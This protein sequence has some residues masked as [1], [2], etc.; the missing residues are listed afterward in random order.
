MPQPAAAPN[1]VSPSQIDKLRERLGAG[2]VRTG[3]VLAPYTTFQIGGPADLFFE[4]HSA[5]EL[6]EAVLAARA[7]GV[8]YFL[9]GLGANI[10]IGDLGFR[11]LVIRNKAQRV[12]IDRE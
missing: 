4:A 3:E 12:E 7:L 5:D 6:A 10:L 1:A 2:R 9:L 8:P 11:G